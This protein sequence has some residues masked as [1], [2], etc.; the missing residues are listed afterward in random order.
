MQ[1]DIGTM[2]ILIEE[3]I[4]RVKKQNKESYLNSCDKYVLTP[5]MMDFG[6]KGMDNL[7]KIHYSKIYR[8][9]IAGQVIDLL[10]GIKDYQL[11]KGEKL[12]EVYPFLGLNTQNY[13]LNGEVSISF[14]KAINTNLIA[15]LPKPLLKKIASLDALKNNNRLHYVGKMTKK[16]ASYLKSLFSEDNKVDRSRIDHLYKKSQKDN[17]NRTL[18]TMLDKYF[19]DFDKHI[20]DRQ[21][22]LLERY[23]YLKNFNGDISNL[24]YVKGVFAGIK[25]YPPLGFNPLPNNDPVEREKVFTL[26][27]YCINKQIPITTHCV[28]EGFKVISESQFKYYN[29]T[30]TWQKVLEIPEFNNLKIN[31][32]HF[33]NDE[34]KGD[35]PN[36]KELETIFNLVTNPAYPN[37][38]T[39]ISYMLYNQECYQGFVKL[40]SKLNPDREQL[41]SFYENFLF[42]TDFSINLKDSNSYEN[43]LCNF[44]Q[45]ENASYLTFN[46][47]VD[48]ATTNP[49][50]FL[51]SK[52]EIGAL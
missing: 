34:T 47:K 18:I 52:F 32:A 13:S 10:N 50:K 37:V 8:K 28:T 36:Y 41:I 2:L 35:I 38:Y 22:Y 33:G 21:D 27:R 43:Y 51:F 48:I 45:K 25:V 26:Y 46:Q 11:K 9:P 20:A 24:K 16:D 31:F 7:Q 49:E 29:S 15:S 23:N 40:M 44:V 4:L 5:L 6:H 3:D 17:R 19:S 30:S 42:G 12:L 14:D 1:N 39:D